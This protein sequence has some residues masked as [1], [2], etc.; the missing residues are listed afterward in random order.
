M[1][2]LYN[3]AIQLYFLA[4][5]LV[6]N[7]N[8]KAALWIAGRKQQLIQ[9]QDNSIWFH[10]ASLGE[11]E[12]GRPVVEAIKKRKPG[13]PVV[14]TFFSPSGYEIRKNTPLAD[15]VYYLP[16]DTATNAAEFINTIKPQM[17]IFTKY[18]Y[19]YHF[20]N[21]LHKKDIPVYMISSIF[22]QDQIFFKW[23]GSLY[24]QMLGM[25][26]HFFVQDENSKSLLGS[27]GFNNVTVNGDT[28]FDRVWA[29]ANHPNELPLIH[30]F[31]NNY[32]VF[33]AGSTWP[34]DEQLLAALINRYPQWKF[35]FAPHE[36]GEDKIES[37]IKLLPSDRT[38][39]FST[40]SANEQLASKNQVLVI[41]NIGMLSSLYQYGEIAY[42]G[43]GFGVGIHNTLEAAAFGLPVIFGPK[44]QKFKEARDLIALKAGISINNQEALNNAADLFIN[45]TTYR[46]LASKKIKQYVQ[47]NTGATAA[48]LNKIG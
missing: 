39:R 12:Q 27:I 47:E 22:R 33:I 36:V 28:R 41:D 13:V 34:Q 24:R 2:L 17:A 10:F 40:L 26:N 16:L 19:W 11:F 43:G 4:I 37:L 38:I 30:L 15:A 14:I 3:T 46:E 31:K 29:N 6:A 21:V 35:I 44:Y 45:D 8:K 1:L 7:F 9:N 23:Y 20:F 25:V 48:I 42:I 5:R 18:E 32:P